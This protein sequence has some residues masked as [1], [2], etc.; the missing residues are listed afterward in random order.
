MSWRLAIDNSEDMV[1]YEIHHVDPLSLMNTTELLYKDLE[2]T[3]DL[4]IGSPELPIQEFPWY[5]WYKSSQQQ[6]KPAPHRH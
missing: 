4:E 2:T 5:E 6:L 1:F 3:K